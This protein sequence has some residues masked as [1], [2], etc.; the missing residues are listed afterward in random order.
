[1]ATQ[2][3]KLELGDVVEQ[4]R[5]W[6]E[7]V[8]NELREPE[9]HD[10]A[11]QTKRQLDTAIECL[12]FCEKHQ[13]RPRSEVVTLPMTRTATPSSNYR[14][15]EDHETEHREQWTELEIGGEPVNLY[16]GDLIVR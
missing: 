5:S 1:M 8:M 15:I 14:V 16:A 4:L 13:I 7:Q 11:L 6:R 12:E 10:K 2:K 3:H 9:R